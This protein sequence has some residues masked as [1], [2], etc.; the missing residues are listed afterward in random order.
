[1]ENTIKKGP[2]VKKP[3]EN[4]PKENLEQKGYLNSI[5]SIIDFGGAQIV[6][7]FVS[8]FIVS[9]LGSSLYGIWQM[10]GQMT[11][12][13]NMADTRASQVLKWSVAKNRD[14]ATPEEL[15]GE[16][17]SALLI[18]AFILPLVLVIGAVVVW[19]APVITRADETYYE[20]IRIVCAILMFSLVI[21]KVFDIFEAVLRGMNLGYKRM[22]IRVGII[23][24]G[25]LLKI[26]VI[27]QGYGLIGLSL[28]EI[29]LALITGITF[30]YIVKKNVSWFGF[31]KTTRSKTIT[32]GKLSGWFMAFSGARIFLLNS[33]K[34]V[35]GYLIG[36]IFVTQYTITMFTTMAVQGLIYA[37]INGIIPGIGS[38]FGKMKFNKVKKAR[39]LINNLNWLMISS[40]GV[41]ILLFNQSFIGLWIGEE[42]Y[43]GT[44]ENLFILL[45][46]VQQIFFQT[47]SLIINVSL[48]VK[49]KV[50]FS[51]VATALTL[52]L[53]YFLVKEYGIVG[54]CWSILLGRLILTLGY[55]I[56]LKRKMSDPEGLKFGP[57]FRPLF[58]LLIFFLT[59]SYLSQFIL[60]SN[61]IGLILLGG[62]SS[63]I[64]GL[65]FWFVG[66]SP[67]GRKDILKVISKIEL[68]KRI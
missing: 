40:L 9:G 53:A 32:Y 62:L 66:I 25:G 7:F 38:L 68:L 27:T 2:K 42:H 61:W 18:T 5:T 16:V 3:K 36:P 60:V 1:M 48:D 34:I 17:T 44:V 65:F 15:Q 43:A 55:P 39:N 22:G 56:I 6:G 37:V 58:T 51:L 54:L 57:M 59:A 29:V 35:L 28:V 10:L 8:P 31:G 30:Y 21:H 20:L 11:G 24:F 67:H 52:F 4:Q 47:D 14:I 50:Y 41:G 23:A 33:D 13:A 64:A 12:F 63:L 49:R 45:I 46:S 26:L 19:Y